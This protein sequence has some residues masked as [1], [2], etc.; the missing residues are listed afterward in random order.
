MTPRPDGVGDWSAPIRRYTMGVRCDFHLHTHHS[1]GTLPPR[2]LLA[3]VRRAGLDRFAVTD[4]D[5]LAG[6]A[7]LR[8]EAGLVTGVEI[9]AGLDGREIHIVGL[10]F[11]ADDAAFA[12][13]LSGIRAIRLERLEA[14][15]ARLPARISRGLTMDEL[16]REPEFS[17]VDAFGRLHLA[18]M[19]IKRGGVASI[20]AAFDQHLGDDHTADAGLAPYPHP[21][22]CCAAIHAAGGVAILAHPGVHGDI[23]RIAALAALGCD[24]IEIDHPNLAPELAAPLRELAARQGLLVSSGSDLHFLGARRPGGWCLDAELISPLL[25]RIGA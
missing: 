5:T 25:D 24:G 16:R 20:G 13:V 21:A 6:S 22:L 14:L 11:A 17:H 15:I 3:A 4:H 8:G 10:G 2:E 18:K 12:A 7:A 1:D 9:T 19:L 23:G